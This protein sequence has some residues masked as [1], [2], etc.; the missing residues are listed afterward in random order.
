MGSLEDPVDPYL[1]SPRLPTLQGHWHSSKELE[2][3]T[4]PLGPAVGAVLRC[5]VPAP[6]FPANKLPELKPEATGRP[7]SPNPEAW[8]SGRRGWTR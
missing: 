4:P 3:N 2:A 5:P 7:A 6:I 8:H 1:P